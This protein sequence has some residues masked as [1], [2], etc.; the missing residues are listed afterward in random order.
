MIYGQA[1]EQLIIYQLWESKAKIIHMYSKL[2]PSLNVALK[3]SSKRIFCRAWIVSAIC[4]FV[5]S[6]M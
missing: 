2:Q 1:L 3:D 5:I 4:L 6:S